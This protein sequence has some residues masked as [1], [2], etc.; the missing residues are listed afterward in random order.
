M[1]IDLVMVGGRAV[2]FLAAITCAESRS[3]KSRPNSPLRTDLSAS[4]TLRRLTLLPGRVSVVV[5]HT[6]G[7]ARPVAQR[8]VQ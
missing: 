4:G 2:G 5:P 3:G 7:R 8:F 6:I 1:V